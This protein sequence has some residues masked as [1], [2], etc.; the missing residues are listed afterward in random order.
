[1][2]RVDRVFV[3]AC[4]WLVPPLAM[5]VP[6]SSRDTGFDGGDGLKLLVLAALAGLAA[7]TVADWLYKDG[8]WRRVLPLIG[9]VAY[10]AFGLV[11]VAWSPLPL[12]SMD[13]AGTFG[14]LC[15]F[16]LA[17]SQATR[18]P[19]D[20]RRWMWHLSY[21]QL[22]FSAVI[23]LAH[24]ADPTMAGLDRQRIHTGG[25]GL[26]H[27]T[28]SGSTASLGLLI[29][30]LCHRVLRFDWIRRWW[31]PA[32]AIH[33]PILLLSNSRM[34]I[35]LLALIGIPLAWP[36]VSR[37]MK[38]RLLAAAG[39]VAIGV[40]LFD[41]G[42]VG[43][44]ESAAEVGRYITRG[45][46]VSQIRAVSGRMEMWNAIFGEIQK[47][48]W[49]GHGFFVTSQTGAIEVW[50]HKE[51]YLAHNFL[52]QSLA[53]TGMIGTGLLV[54]SL[55]ALCVCVTRLMRRGPGSQKVAKFAIA[56]GLWYL[57]WGLLAASFLGPIRPE[58]LVFF[59]TVG[60]VTAARVLSQADRFDDRRPR[61][62][63][64]NCYT[65]GPTR[66]TFPVRRDADGRFPA[67][68]PSTA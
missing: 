11:S 8:R 20:I 30:L 14:V 65:A 64:A 18:G 45:Q 35:L 10:A 60:L 47:S 50:Y 29:G 46:D 40:V 67:E 25:D 6:K 22:L 31:P 33:G 56:I 28:A 32:L 38:A 19:D 9:L 23:L 15:I 48:P 57:G 42:F 13:K 41:S 34:S 36:L 63:S 7:W 68:A 58:S 27:P 3:L 49:L 2:N 5:T 4:L 17:V 54:G 62:L 52:L 61:E 26:I 43:I 24:V 44:G 21:S 16:A 51:N 37:T 66:D 39:L 55:L 12:V 53:T 1:M 59:L